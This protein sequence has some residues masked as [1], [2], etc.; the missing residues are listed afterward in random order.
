M[1]DI[2]ASVCAELSERLGVPCSTQVPAQRPRE[3]ATVERTGGD[4]QPGRDA[5]NLAVQVWAQSESDAYALA[6]AARVV[7]CDLRETIP[8]VCSVSVGGIYSFPD[9]DSR[10]PR[11][12]LDVQAVT[13]P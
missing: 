2:L 4:Y 1:F 9:P 11:Y 6:L 7:L 3:F 12:Q 10:Q 13:R 8:S 5:P